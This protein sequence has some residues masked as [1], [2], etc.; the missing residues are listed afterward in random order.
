MI[1]ARAWPAKAMYFLIAAA[2]VI[3]L[4]IVAAPAQK[5]SAQNNDVAAEWTRVDTPTREGFV[6]AD[7]S[8]IIDYHTASAGEVAYAVVYA[9]DDACSEGQMYRLLKSDDHCATWDDLT[10]ALEDVDDD[11]S[12]QTIV[13]V[14]TDWDDPDF[15]AVALMEDDEIRVYFSID[16]GD[17]FEDAGWVEDG[18]EYFDIPYR[19]LRSR[20]TAI[21]S[22]LKM[23]APSSVKT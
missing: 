15:M 22:L 18:G 12:I 11:D 7:E 13:R 17:T 6:L 16:G 10:E 3:S 5:A 4:I 9:Y 23:R 2:L 19:F 8:M 14:A 1:K 21:L 20:S